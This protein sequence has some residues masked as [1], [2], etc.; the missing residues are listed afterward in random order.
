[1]GNGYDGWDQG[2]VDWQLMSKDGQ[3]TW[4]SNTQTWSWPLFLLPPS[5]LGQD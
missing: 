5:G 4:A 2:R 3:V 1:M